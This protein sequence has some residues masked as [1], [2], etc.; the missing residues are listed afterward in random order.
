VLL[1]AFDLPH[2]DGRDLRKLPLAERKAELQRVV[3]ESGVLFSNELKGAPAILI[4]L[5]K[6]AKR[7]GIV[8][9]L[10]ESIYDPGARSEGWRKL[11]LKPQQEFVVGGYRPAGKRGLELLLVGFYEKRKLLYAGKVRIGLNRFNR[12]MLFRRL[13]PLRQSRC[14]FDN[15]PNSRTDHFGESVTAE[16][17]DEYVWVK[18]ELVVQVKFAEWTTGKV[19]RH[20]EFLGIGE[21]KDPPEVQRE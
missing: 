3:Q 6:K 2:L 18:P 9:K 20:A 8:A 21:D 14:P 12:K 17:M 13:N 10:R 4:R 15:L 16:D 7:E 11:Q 19:L 1:C 5:G